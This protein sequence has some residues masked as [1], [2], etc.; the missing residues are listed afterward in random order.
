MPETYSTHEYAKLFATL[1][2][3]NVFLT[4][5]AGTGKTT[6]LHRLRESSQKQMA[7]VAPTGVAAINAGGTT[8]HSFFQ[9][10][11][12]PFVPTEWGKK[13]LVSKMKMVANRRKVLRELELLV[14]DE[15]SM[16]RADVLDAIDTVLRHVRYRFNEPFGGVQMIFIGDMYQLSPVA[17]QGEWQILSQFYKGVY[18]FNS[19]VFQEKPFVHIEFEKIFRQ[20]DIEFIQVLNEVRNN[21]L[22]VESQALLDKRYNPLFVPSKDD[23]YVILT[24]HNYKADLINREEL[25]KIDKTSKFFK[26]HIQGDFGERSY[27]AEENLKLKIGAK[28]MFIKNDNETPRRFFNGKIGVVSGWKDDFILV[29]CPEDETEIEVLPVEWENIRYKA[30]ETTLEVK[31]ELLGSFR[32][33]PLRLAWAITI[34][35]SQGLTFEKAVID[36]GASFAPG[37]VYVALSRC[38]SLEG[39][40]L[41]S[42][43]SS[44]AIQNDSEILRFS[45]RQFSLEQLQNNF[46]TSRHHYFLTLLL[47]VFDFRQMVSVSSRWLTRTNEVASSFSSETI[48]YLRNINKQLN[49]IQDVGMK[50]G[51]QIAQVVNQMP[52]NEDFLNLRL[53]A[54]EKYFSEKLDM[55]IETLKQS[56]AV[57]DSRDNGREFDDYFMDIHTF[58]E[59]KR[60]WIKGIRNGFSIEKY[61]D[62]RKSFV[63]PSI[64]VSSY[65]R[66]QSKT[67]IKSRNPELLAQLFELRNSV[68]DESGLPIYLIANSKTIMEMADFLPQNKAD[69]LKISGIGEA[70]Y[71]RFGGPFLEII[72]NYCEENGIESSMEE[73]FDRVKRERKPKKP[74]GAS[75]LETLEAFKLGKSVR[76]IA[77][78]RNLAVGTISGHLAEFV[79]KGE[80]DAE[81]I[82]GK[83]K[84]LKAKELVENTE[85]DGSVYGLLKEHFEAG[86]LSIILGWLRSNA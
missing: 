40:V 50:F 23:T 58:A 84:L 9:L 82:V 68:V 79:M 38:R 61:F 59:Q 54:S 14:I 63:L 15:I 16:V 80:V 86:E 32:Q 48:D 74:K 71:E 36:A 37:Q 17:Q 66:K 78:E 41:Q 29:K 85:Y 64:A 65:S 24:T 4:G 13:E 52:F 72:Q 35:K 33:Y 2:N 31:E 69:M 77:R 46:S 49:D 28:V 70:K 34:H 7:V 27:P 26:A 42:K 60:H 1:T 43:I 81:R 22:S 51:C 30:D 53:D 5:K 21:C 73:L 62:L 19:Q 83:E 47:G 18:F 44:Q 39:M 11:L 3:Q 56:P 20:S 57:T 8:I 10:P 12:T 45:S 76:E 55:L 6:F 25:D 75:A 67:K